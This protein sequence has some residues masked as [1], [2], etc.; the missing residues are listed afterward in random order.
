MVKEL[1]R[2]TQLQH[3][4][5]LSRMEQL[6]QHHLQSQVVRAAGQEPVCPALFT[7]RAVMRSSQKPLVILSQG[8]FHT[9]SIFNLRLNIVLGV[10]INFYLNHRLKVLGL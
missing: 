3:L 5:P 4:A 6:P 7:S 8:K 9:P 2:P 1:L 10:Q